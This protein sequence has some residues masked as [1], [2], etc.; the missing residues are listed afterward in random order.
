[1]STPIIAGGS[2]VRNA[3]TAMENASVNWT[4]AQRSQAE[5]ILDDT[6]KKLENFTASPQPPV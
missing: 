1:M 4:T 2:G 6:R 5:K 3:V